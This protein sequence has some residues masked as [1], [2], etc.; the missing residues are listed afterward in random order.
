MGVWLVC[1]GKASPGR[2]IPS[3]VRE[4]LGFPGGSVGKESACYAG[5]LGSIPGSGRFPGEGSDSPLQYL[6]W[7]IPWTEEPGELQSMGGRVS[8]IQ[9]KKT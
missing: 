2:G 4:I 8:K 7:R 5:N 6:A 9:N 3:R 1:I